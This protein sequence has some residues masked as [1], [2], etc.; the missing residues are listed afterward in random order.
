MFVCTSH[1]CPSRGTLQEINAFRP[2][3]REGR[4]K[5]IKRFDETVQQYKN[6][7]VDIDRLNQVRCK[8]CITCRERVKT[9]QN[10]PKTEFGKCRF[11][12]KKMREEAVCELCSSTENIEFDHIDPSTKRHRL[13]SYDWW[14]RHGGVEAMKE[15]FAKCR[16]LCHK[17]HDYVETTRKRKYEHI[18]DMPTD[19]R[20]EKKTK[21][22]SGIVMKKLHM[23]WN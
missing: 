21:D 19:T 22:G 18:D 16:P 15:E 13:G 11:F 9:S 8:V 4:A 10:D 6:G 3:G 5:A 1:T 20:K 17:C 12:Y 23:Y 7:L 14:P 2:S